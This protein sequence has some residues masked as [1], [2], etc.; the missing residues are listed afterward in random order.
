MNILYV[1]RMHAGK[2]FAGVPKKVWRLFLCFLI[3]S[4]FKQSLR[5]L[6]GQTMLVQNK[7][8]LKKNSELKEISKKKYGM[9][10][11]FGRFVVHF[12]SLSLFKNVRL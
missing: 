6:D 7:I 5:T 4:C 12:H 1:A 8:Y 3:P 11:T 2:N 9:F 10:S